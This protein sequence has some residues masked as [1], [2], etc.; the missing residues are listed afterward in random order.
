M[1]HHP[2]AK[3]SCQDLLSRSRVISSVCNA[4]EWIGGICAN[5][6]WFKMHLKNISNVKRHFFYLLLEYPSFYILHWIIWGRFHLVASIWNGI[7]HR[8]LLPKLCQKLKLADYFSLL[9]QTMDHLSVPGGKC[10]MGQC[11]AVMMARE[12]AWVKTILGDAQLLAAEIPASQIWGG[13]GGRGESKTK[14]GTFHV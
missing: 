10:A 2:S 8:P 7:T 1:L 5:P 9:V 13:G 3:T 12:A 6:P 4:L 14:I 11:R